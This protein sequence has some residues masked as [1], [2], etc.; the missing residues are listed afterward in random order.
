M[1]T[2]KKRASTKKASAKKASAKKGAAKQAPTAAVTGDRLKL[3]FPLS[4]SKVAAIQRCVAKGK[5]SVTVSKASLAAGQIG[6]P[7]LYD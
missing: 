1:P 5:L 6:D 2:S 7:W 4:A 3:S